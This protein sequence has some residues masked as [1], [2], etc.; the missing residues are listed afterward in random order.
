MNYLD[1]QPPNQEVSVSQKKTLIIVPTYNERDN[2]KKLALEILELDLDLDLLFIDDNSP[3]GTGQIINE[4]A[5]KH[6]NVFAVHRP[7]KLGIGS[8]HLTG[9][10]WAY[11]N[12]YTT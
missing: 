7:S 6:E 12:G 10:K 9:I 5:S 4:L 2:A 1:E 11:A 3:D 8:A